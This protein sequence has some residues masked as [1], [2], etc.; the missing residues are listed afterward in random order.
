MDCCI[1]E[2][3]PFR[4]LRACIARQQGARPFELSVRLST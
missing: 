4:P 2:Q 1:R 3:H